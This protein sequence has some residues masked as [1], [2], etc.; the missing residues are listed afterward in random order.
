[1]VGQFNEP[2]AYGAEQAGR[3]VTMGPPHSASQLESGFESPVISSVLAREA[4][5][6]S[7]MKR[8]MGEFSG[9]NTVNRLPVAQGELARSHKHPPAPG[10][11]RLLRR[12]TNLHGFPDQENP[13]ARIALVVPAPGTRC[14][15]PMIRFSG[16]RRI[17]MQ[18]NQHLHQK[19]QG[20]QDHEPRWSPG[21]RT[22]RPAYTPRRTPCSPRAAPAG[23]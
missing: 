4:L 23:C 15:P 11:R 7:P 1:M 13:Y 12:Q 17:S 8:P 5:M 18:S 16:F 6:H 3:Q 14:H 9:L 19:Q 10:R 22:L 2:V 21:S 20:N